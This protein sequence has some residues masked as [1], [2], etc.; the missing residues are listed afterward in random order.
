MIIGIDASRANREHKTGTEWYSYYLIKYFAQFDAENQ[1]ILYSDSP[2]QGGLLDLG[3]VGLE[4]EGKREEPIYDDRGFQVI[5]S[6]HGNFRGDVLRWPV[7][8][9]WTLGRLSLEML[10]HKPDLLFVPAHGLPLFRPKRTVNTVHD[11]SFR[12]EGANYIFEKKKL[13]PKSGRLRKKLVDW[14]V[15]F[16]T[17]GK[18]GANAFDYLD[19]STVYSLK[20]SDK[21]ITVSNYSRQQILKTYECDSKDIC[22]SD[23]IK[24]VHNGF[25]DQIYKKIDDKEAVEAVLKKYGIERPYL[26]YT[27]RLERKKNTPFLIEAFAK[28]KTKHGG[29]KER[30]VLVG[31]ASFGYDEVKYLTHQYGLSS[32]IIMTGWVPESDMPYIVN[33]ASAFIFPSIHEGFGIPVLQAM[34]CGVPV[35][36][37]DI[38]VLR[39]IVGDAALYFD[40][41]N[42]D[43]ASEAIFEILTNEKMK[44]G[45]SE[46]GLARAKQFSWEKC[47]RETL[48]VLK[49]LLDD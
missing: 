15:R 13:G 6:P 28:A 9:L 36:L 44:K 49:G 37:S 30:L 39:E 5:K 8:Y 16:G 26:L 48:G 1:Y 21:I 10:F 42:K 45:L 24:V 31:D 22:R 12:E 11:V 40:P 14:L 4:D 17:R 25:N 43:K 18:Y 38:P 33:G 47:A 29:I 35:V 3:K 20:H 34:N 23:K 27:G 19:W 32:D 41:R 46:A 7:P 2:L